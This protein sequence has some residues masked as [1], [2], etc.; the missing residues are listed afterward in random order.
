MATEVEIPGGKAFFRERGVD[1]IPGDSVKLIKSAYRAARVTLAEF[2]QF[3]EEQREGES[4]EEYEERIAGMMKGVVLTTEQ[5]MVWEEL[6]EATVVAT[7]KSWTLDRP[8]PTLRTIGDLDQ[9]LYEAL[10]DAA[11]G[12]GAQQLE[13]DFSVKRDKIDPATGE[14]FP[15]GGSSDSEWPSETDRESPSTTTSSTDSAPSSGGDSSPEQ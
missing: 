8:L 6:R 11:G 13:T 1:P 12:I 3:F 15:T 2:P 4:D 7:L 10:L 9:D 5:A 14:E